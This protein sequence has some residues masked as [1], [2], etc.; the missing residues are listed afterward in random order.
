MPATDGWNLKG[1]VF[2]DNLDSRPLCTLFDP[3]TIDQRQIIDTTGSHTIVKTEA[4]GAR[5]TN[6]AGQFNDLL[7]VALLQTDSAGRTGV[8]GKFY[9]ARGIGLIR[10]LLEEAQ[11]RAGTFSGLIDLSSFHV[12]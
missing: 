12:P 10:I 2:Y 4:V 7:V 1:A 5:V 3:P 8:R 9:L 11:T 6:A